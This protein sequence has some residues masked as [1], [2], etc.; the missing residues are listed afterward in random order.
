M[1]RHAA[2]ISSIMSLKKLLGHFIS[3]LLQLYDFELRPYQ[4]NGSI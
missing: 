1:G 2:A 3:D 4:L